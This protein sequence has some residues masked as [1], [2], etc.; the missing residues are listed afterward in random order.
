MKKLV[1][2]IIAMSIF[3]S[4][5][6]AIFATNVSYMADFESADAKFGNSTTYS[7]TK[8]TAG[9][10]SDFVKP[11]WV[12]DGGKE[13]STGLRITYKA[14]T[15]YAGEVF[16]PIP[17]AWQ[18]GADAE[19]LNF[20]YNGK[21]IVNISLSTGSAATDTLTKGTKYSYKLNADTNGE[22]Q[23]ISIPLSE[24]KNNGN[25]VTIANIGCVTFQAGENGGLSN[26]ASETKAMTAAELEAKARN[27]SIIFDNME[28]SNVGEN[29][30]NPNATPEPTE[31]PDNT[32][33]TIDF[34]TYTLSHKQTWA[35]F[36]NNDKTYSDSIKSEITE[37]GKEGC[38]LELTY[39]AASWYAGE[40]FM[41]IPKEWAI[42]KNSECLEFDANGQ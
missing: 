36:N 42:Y 18:N 38:A 7:G 35:G 1:S 14:A 31:K 17:V 6:C 21:G 39:K 22:W 4:I 2:L 24:F 15:W 19:Y 32:T 28:L 20:D 8:N 37:N 13:N 33:R 34:D 5:N 29:V 40:I 25:P 12:A 30:L 27:G 11:E 16:F 23:S 9:D 26:S 3:F 10:Y 41:S